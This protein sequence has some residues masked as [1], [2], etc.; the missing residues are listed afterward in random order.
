MIKLKKEKE[1]G[2]IKRKNWWKIKGRCKYKS[3]TQES[4]KE[5]EAKKWRNR[6][7]RHGKKKKKK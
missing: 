2:R 1:K 5:K 3:M 7:W 6:T 4:E